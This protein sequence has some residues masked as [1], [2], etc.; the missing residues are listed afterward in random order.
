MDR[1]KIIEKIQ[2]YIFQMS[3]L[4]YRIIERKVLEDYDNIIERIE[5]E[6]E[7]FKGH[8]EIL[9]SILVM[10]Q[11]VKTT[12]EELCYKII[13]KY[14]QKYFKKPLEEALKKENINTIKEITLKYSQQAN[15]KIEIQNQLIK[16]LEQLSLKIN[17][18]DEEILN[19][20]IERVYHK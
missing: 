14:T 5:I 11:Y 7:N 9:I 4:D 6:K 3:G 8:T 12:Y 16:Y 17:T 19:K 13:N 10:E 15:Y 20:K 18:E 1:V 2:N